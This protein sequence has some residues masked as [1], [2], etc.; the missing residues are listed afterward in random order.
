MFC[1]MI[2]ELMAHEL[3]TEARIIC[4]KNVRAWVS[5]VSYLKNLKKKYSRKRKKKV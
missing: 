5:V 1:G 2:W 3:T 4:D